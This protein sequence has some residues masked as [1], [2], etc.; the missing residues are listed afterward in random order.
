MSRVIR[1]WV[2]AAAVFGP[3]LT[4]STGCVGEGGYVDEYPGS[5]FY[6][7]YGGDYGAFDSG[8]EIGPYRRFNDFGGGPIG[9][10]FGTGFRG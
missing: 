3:L 2:V 6:Q 4:L 5:G 10:R 9:R 7:P 1:R 8:F